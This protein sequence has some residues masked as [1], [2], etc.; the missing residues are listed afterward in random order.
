M[1]FLLRVFLIASAA[2]VVSRGAAAPRLA[3]AASTNP[4][5]LL[6][7]AEASAAL[8]ATV[9]KPKLV[10]GEDNLEC[11][12]DA[13]KISATVMTSPREAFCLAMS[14]GSATKPF[15]QIAPKAIYVFNLGSLFVPQ[16][17]TC[18]VISLESTSQDLSSMTKDVPPAVV[19]IASKVASR[20]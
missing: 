4:C 7:A 5:S 2:L 11:H 18:A 13:A 1:R 12:Y 10:K 3:F 16:H 19:T 14:K 15:P 17:G 6:T 20:L 9:G 8:G